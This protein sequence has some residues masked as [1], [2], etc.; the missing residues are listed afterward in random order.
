MKKFSFYTILVL[1]FSLLFVTVASAESSGS[2]GK[3]AT[4]H[5]DEE[6]AI[7][8]ISGTG[9][10]DN[11]TTSLPKQLKISDRFSLVVEE[12]ITSIGDYMFDFANISTVSLPSTLSKIG[13]RAFYSSYF[14]EINLPESLVFI[15]DYAFSFCN[16]VKNQQDISTLQ[17]IGTQAF[18]S[19]AIP[20]KVTISASTELGSGAFS[21]CPQLTELTIENGTSSIQTGAFS[22]CLKL[23]KVSIPE[24]IEKIGRGAFYNCPNVK[25]PVNF[26]NLKDIGQKAFSNS[27]VPGKVTIFASSV[28]ENAFQN[29]SSL[30]EVTLDD[31]I[32]TI[33]DSAFKDCKSLEKVNNFDKIKEFAVNAFSG[34]E[35][36]VFEKITVKK[37]VTYHP[38]CLAG[39]AVR[40]VEYEEGN[41]ITVNYLFSGCKQLKKVTLPSTVT[42]VS[43]GTFRNCEALDDINTP[44][45]LKR[46]DSDAF[47]N[48]GFTAVTVRKGISYYS[49]AYSHC[50]KLKEVVFEEGKTWT[51][52]LLFL[53]CTALERVE[54]PSSVTVIGTKSFSGC[55]SLKEI[56]LSNIKKIEKEAFSHSLCLTEVNL[57]KINEIQTDAFLGCL[58]LRKV[59]TS[60]INAWASVTF[61]NEYAN[62]VYYAKCIYENGEPVFFPRFN[63]VYRIEAYAFVN[64][65]SFL[66]VVFDGPVWSVDK[67][68]FSGCSKLKTVIL[69]ERALSFDSTSFDKCDSIR[70]FIDFSG[71]YDPVSIGFYL[72]GKSTLYTTE[73]HSELDTL[74]IRYELINKH[75]CETGGHKYVDGYF[76]LIGAPTCTVK[77]QADYK[78]IFCGKVKWNSIGKLNHTFTKIATEPA[79]MDADGKITERCTLCGAEKETPIAKIAQVGFRN[80]DTLYRDSISYD[81]A[82]SLVAT[83]SA[84]KEIPK[85]DVIGTVTERNAT[86]GVVKIG[87]YGDYTGSTEITFRILP[88][89]IN[90][91][92]KEYG[93]TSLKLGWEKPAFSSQ[94]PVE[95][96][97][98]EDNKEFRS[99]GT[100]TEDN[101]T[102]ESLSDGKKYYFKAVASNENGA[103]EPT[104]LTASTRKHYHTPVL[105][106][107]ENKTCL[108]S[109]M[110]YYECSVCGE[111]WS[112]EIKATGHNWKC[113]NVIV[114][115]TCISTGYKEYKCKDCDKTLSIVVPYSDHKVVTDPIVPATMT[116]DGKGQGSHCSVCNEIL[117]EQ[118]PIAKAG[119]MYIPT[120]YEYDGLIHKPEVSAFD[121]NGDEIGESNYTVKYSS[122]SPKA[123]G[124]YT[125]TVTMKHYYSGTKVLTFRI[126]PKQVTGLKCDK[127]TTTAVTLSWAKV[128]GAKYY[129]VEQSADGKKWTTAATVTTNTATVN[130]LK[131]GTKYQF[132]VTALDATKKYA[133]K[134]SAVLKTA[135]L[136]VAPAIKLTST[137]SNTATVSWSKVAGAGKYY[138]YLSTDGKKWTARYTVS[139][140]S[141]TMTKLTGGKKIY[142]KVQA[143]NAYN[144][145]SAYSPVKNITVKK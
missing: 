100:T 14:E 121:A 91:K 73:Y 129:K 142:V 47:E 63:A 2:C 110:K 103:G 13:E 120:T 25:T 135:T 76:D 117:Q 133:G 78:C 68:A 31:S 111:T 49:S 141:Y 4:W 3:N 112:E 61:E 108:K 50:K 39:T 136:T 132:R 28:S 140:T 137:K 127:V 83:D 15:G 105:K 9:E 107:T 57:P 86:Y 116:T 35:S 126:V 64:C 48:T 46:I 134:M 95:L 23:E 89:K 113:T 118:Y 85:A 71:Q 40:E 6:K 7:L 81:V 77:G 51:G 27:S 139:G 80:S 102:V 17:Y 124:T 26:S 70:N 37:D 96:F 19:S 58:N 92:V 10:T 11:Y 12:G 16:K 53:G 97:I 72:P 42:T 87:F 21:Y 104:C 98:S 1:A 143:V 130:S 119:T 41:T 66:S 18:Y 114:E 90:L 34:C 38:Y 69:L 84:G 79:S 22:N 45:S 5:Y 109:G 75:N 128:A 101:L 82:N 123:I 24:N 67:Y 62:P 144:R 32:E 60:N 8:T 93:Q 138:V 125:V 94:T 115:P 88:E 145:S 106:K 20:G 74:N 29:C 55:S 36:L 65:S 52:E 59:N 43:I 131:A 30:T 33:M 44:E 122:D 56:D 99:L 54:L